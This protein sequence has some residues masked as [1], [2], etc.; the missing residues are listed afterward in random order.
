MLVF[1]IWKNMFVIMVVW[2][3]CDVCLS[4]KNNYCVCLDLL[5][6]VEQWNLSKADTIGAKIRV[7]LNKMSAL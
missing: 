1:I 5:E 6:M 2:K 7:R 3:V 4:N